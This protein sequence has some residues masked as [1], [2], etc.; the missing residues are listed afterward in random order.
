MLVSRVSQFS[1]ISR[2]LDLPITQE[3]LDSWMEGKLIQEAFPHLS[4][5]QREFLMTGS[6]PEEWAKYI[7]E[8]TFLGEDDG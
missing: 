8:D 2:T 6:T 3:Q 5:D 7:V 4:A 1:G